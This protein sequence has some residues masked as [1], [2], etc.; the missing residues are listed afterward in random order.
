[1]GRG[2]TGHI[3]LYSNF[4]VGRPRLGRLQTHI[5]RPKAAA[6][7]RA[8][9]ETSWAGAPFS[10]LETRALEEG[11]AASEVILAHVMAVVLW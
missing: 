3:Y 7:A 1:M 6:A 11:E 9:D 8:Q 5:K 4:F 2:P 10:W